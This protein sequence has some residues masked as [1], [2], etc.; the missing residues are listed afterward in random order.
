MKHSFFENKTIQNGRRNHPLK[1]L[2]KIIFLGAVFFIISIYINVTDDENPTQVLIGEKGI[3]PDGE[4]PVQENGKDSM[5]KEGLENPE[6]GLVQFIGKDIKEASAAWGPPDRVDL[7]AFGYEWWVYSDGKMYRQLAVENGKVVSAYAIGEDVD[8]SPFYI[9]QPLDEVYGSLSVETS[10]EI[11]TDEGS[12]RFELS[13]DDMNMRPLIRIGDVFAQLYLDKFTGTVSSIRF[14]NEEILLKQRPY[15]LTYRGNLLEET[16][17]LPEDWEKVES[18]NKQQ[19]FDITNIMRSRFGLDQL[20]WDEPISEVAFLHSNDMSASDYFS[21]ISPTHGELKDR[22]EE[23]DISY[24]LAGENIAAHYVDAIA[25]ME[26]WLNSKG[27][28]EALLNEEFTHLGV[29]VFQDYYT[30]NFITK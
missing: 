24:T 15:E 17:L 19:I 4:W 2:G 1:T 14:L 26:G 16:E 20:T 30:Q 11:K 5:K 18:G 22:L 13:E 23:A 29:G 10:V 25:A 9:G 28:R 12:Y 3:N 7:S 6:N 8:V 27:H 21:H